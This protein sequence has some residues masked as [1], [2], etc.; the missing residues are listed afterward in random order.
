[1]QYDD[2]ADSGLFHKKTG[3]T[4]FF[5]HYA[6]YTNN[7]SYRDFAIELTND[8]I[9]QVRQDN[10]TGYVTGLFGV[11]VGVE[12][13]IQNDFIKTDTN[14]IFNNFDNKIFHETVYGNRTDVSF[15]TGLSGLGRYLF[16]RI[17]SHCT[18]EKMNRMLNLLYRKVDTPIIAGFDTD[19]V[20][21]PEQIVET[22]EQI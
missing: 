10:D 20:V 13:L 4:F 14:K 2:I 3:L 5:F 22:V 8:S 12:Y 9:R 17:T 16:F 19:I 11:E 1:M 6:K 21:V 7:K 18:P 15:F